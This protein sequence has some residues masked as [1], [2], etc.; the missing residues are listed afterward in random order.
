MRGFWNHGKFRA[1]WLLPLVVFVGLGEHLMS[2]TS[3]QL[4]P[5][6]LP[7]LEEFVFHPDQF[8]KEA[9]PRRLQPGD[10]A[11]FLMARL[12]AHTPLGALQQAEK[13]VDFYDLNEVAAYLRRFL[14]GRETGPEERKRSIV[15]T[16]ILARSG[17]PEDRRFAAGYLNLLTQRA[18]AT[19]LPGLVSIYEA[20]GP[21]GDSQP[22]RAALN[23]LLSASPSA[24]DARSLQ[25]LLNLTI[26]RA[27]QANTMK[28]RIL[29][30]SE[31]QQRIDG[32]VK[33][34]LALLVGYPEYLPAW[35]ARRLRRETWGENP[36]DQLTRNPSRQR[37]AEVAEAFRRAMPLVEANRAFSDHI[38]SLKRVTCLRAIDF[39]GGALSAA[40]Y[41]EMHTD[42]A[43]QFDV[44]SNY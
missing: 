27:E 31:R 16:R 23:G 15:I 5:S 11:H 35:A 1:P 2:A 7:E 43:R 8:A 22:L 32:E 4:P 25:N 33:I 13:L 21:E 14:D 39:F 40:E 26:P 44:L 36:A 3:S 37:A 29:A 20:L 41:K 9:I 30:I 38:K 12:D 10:V 6:S 19:E 17:A 42:P 28:A 18:T 24:A 34:Y